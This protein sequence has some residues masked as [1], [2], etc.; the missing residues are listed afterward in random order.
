MADKKSVDYKEEASILGGQGGPRAVVFGDKNK[1]KRAA[2]ESSALSQI[3]EFMTFLNMPVNEIERLNEQTDTVEILNYTQR[4]LNNIEEDAMVGKIIRLFNQPVEDW[5]SNANACFFAQF[6]H[7]LTNRHKADTLAS[8]TSEMS[9]DSRKLL[10]YMIDKLNPDYVRGGSLDIEMLDDDSIPVIYPLDIEL[11]IKSAICLARPDLA[12]E[13]EVHKLVTELCELD[14]ELWEQPELDR[15]KF[16]A[17]LFL[18]LNEINLD[19]FTSG[20]ADKHAKRVKEIVDKF[21]N[22]PS[23]ANELELELKRIIK[24]I[25]EKEKEYKNS[26]SE[27]QNFKPDGDREPTQPHIIEKLA[28][29]EELGKEINDMYKRKD[30][31]I[32]Q[33]N[34]LE[35][36]PSKKLH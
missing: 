17:S 5:L 29:A 7:E 10:W 33:L 13:L 9:D 32:E 22:K 35:V 8:L 12:E 24:D 15:A 31:I 11:R 21:Q 30:E 28:A 36:S 20:L 6:I 19:E 34:A 14:D 23:V 16:D 26:N 27:L 4:S 1:P 25:E 18:R 2:K 3:K